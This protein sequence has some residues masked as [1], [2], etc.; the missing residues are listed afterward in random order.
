MFDNF[1]II[2]AIFVSLQTFNNF[3]TSQIAES[4]SNKSDV[5]IITRLQFHLFICSTEQS[6]IEKSMGVLFKE[7]TNFNHLPFNDSTPQN[8][9]IWH[10][11]KPRPSFVSF[12]LSSAHHQSRIRSISPPYRVILQPTYSRSS[13]SAKIQ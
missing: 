12:F 6:A 9:I 10:E 2:S 5:K 4:L 1:C 13:R 11:L 8:R 7:I 3:F